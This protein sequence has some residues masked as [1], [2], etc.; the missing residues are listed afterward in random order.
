M[1]FKNNL[2]IYDYTPYWTELQRVRG[3]IF[4]LGKYPHDDTCDPLITPE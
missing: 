1:L 3:N 2:N 4:S